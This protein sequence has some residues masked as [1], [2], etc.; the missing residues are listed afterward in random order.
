M[1]MIW[2][3]QLLNLIFSLNMNYREL[4]MYYVLSVV[5]LNGYINVMK[6]L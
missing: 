4:S 2:F 3:R 6:L 1:D 5:I